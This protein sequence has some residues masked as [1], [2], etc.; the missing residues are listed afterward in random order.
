MASGLQCPT[1]KHLHPMAELG[2]E[3]VFSCGGCG[4]MLS[5]PASVPRVNGTGPAPYSSPSLDEPT[6]A[7]PPPPPLP[8]SFP[9]SAPPGPPPIRQAP[10][11]AV[12]P[13]GAVDRWEGRPPASVRALVWLVALALGLLATAVP[14]RLLGLLRADQIIHIFA[15]EGLGRFAVLGVVLPLWA[16]A[17]ATVAHVVLEGLTRRPASEPL[18]HSA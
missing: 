5:V 13:A 3:P 6:R 4:R 9:P 8:A 15:G 17:T 2:D 18:R 10:S 14:L 11:R 16:A 7:H 12:S 1:C